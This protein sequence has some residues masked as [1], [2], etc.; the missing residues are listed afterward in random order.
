RPQDFPYLTWTALGPKPINSAFGEFGGAVHDIVLSPTDANRVYLA[1]ASGGLWSS[2]DGGTNWSP[3]TDAQLYL[4]GGCVGIASKA[5]AERVYYMTG[6]HSVSCGD[7]YP[8]FG[9]L[10]SADFA[11]HWSVL[12]DGGQVGTGAWRL[13]VRSGSDAAHD[14][15]YVASNL[16]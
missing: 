14:T 4:V 1:T 3:K 15:I 11:A 5:G 10:E 13:L 2:A 16:G 8:G 6:Q 12:A 9:L 7:L